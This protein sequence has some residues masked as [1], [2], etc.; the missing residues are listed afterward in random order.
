MFRLVK[1]IISE[2]HQGDQDQLG[3]IFSDEKRILVEAP[4][5]CGKTHLM[6]S[7]IAYLLATKQVPSTKQ[8]LALTFSVNAAY[9]VKKDS[10]EK[11]PAL[12]SQVGQPQLDSRNKIFATNYHG[13]ARRILRLYGYLISEHF[14]NIDNF[15]SIDESNQQSLSNLGIGLSFEDTMT[16]SSVANAIKNRDVDTLRNLHDQYVKLVRTALIPNG[17]IPYNAILIIAKDL[18]NSY[19]HI[20][21]GYRNIFSHYIVDEF[22]DT[23]IL[24]LEF[25]LALINAESKIMFM[26]DSLQR[27]YGFIGAVPD[28]I[29]LAESTLAM[30]KHELT[31]N[32]R[33]KDN[34]Y[35]LSI[36]RVI[37]ENAVV[38]CDEIA[39]S[40]AVLK[41]F[42]CPDQTS[43]ALAVSKL[44]NYLLAQEPPGKVAILVRQRGR[45][46]NI[47]IDTLDENQIDYFYALFTDDDSEY[48]RFHSEARKAF[49]DLIAEANTFNKIISDRLV[50]HVIANFK[51]ENAKYFQSLTVLLATFL[52]NIFVKHGHL[53]TEEKISF[54]RDTLEGNALKQSLGDVY[55]RIVVTTVH[56]AKGLEWDY[57]I[58]SDFE[59]STYPHYYGMCRF[60][61]KQSICDL[62]VDNSLSKDILNGFY[63][64]ISVFYVAATRAKNDLYITY[65]NT[66]IANNGTL[67]RKN[68][69]CF[70][71]L[72]GITLQH[73]NFPS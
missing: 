26:G 62:V 25:L 48:I 69:S 54:V 17:Y 44:V 61:N 35:L 55:S 40:S 24:S 52:N 71:K 67:V 64:E 22:Q 63:D 42:S 73:H 59:P 57:V 1:E 9:K 16:L 13:L 31:T 19:P 12:L 23:N 36:D 53:S 47:L 65:S 41:V 39:R 15:K 43:E 29:K 68:V 3:I 11:I 50:K 72:P 32:Y 27:I 14:K 8:I 37:R 38:T 70:L 5:G 21:N 34:H 51:L 18:L 2:A 60:C 46:T 66:G 7:K 30:T 33:F 56:A 10:F 4:A 20:A 49:F 6:I 58:L 45:N 28:L